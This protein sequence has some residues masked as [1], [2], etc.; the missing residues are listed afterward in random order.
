[1]PVF[2]RRKETVMTKEQFEHYNFRKSTLA[3]IERANEIIRDY[4]S[5][6]YS[7]TLRQLYYQFVARGLIENDQKEYKALGSTLSK[8]RLAGLVSWSSIEDRTRNLKGWQGGY[9]DVPDF[10]SGVA[11][12]Y[13]VDIWKGQPTYLE[14][15]VEKDALV[16]VVEKACFE[17]RI[18]HF[19]CRGYS[20]QSEQYSAGKRFHDKHRR[21]AKECHIFHLGDHDPSGIDMT[22]DNQDRLAMFSGDNVTV[23]RIALNMSQIE[24]L[25]PPPNPAKETDSRSDDYIRNYGPNSWELDALDPAYIDRLIREAVTPYIDADA[26]DARRRYEQEGADYLT[27]LS[28]NF[29]AIKAM[30]DDFE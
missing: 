13:F 22:R 4:Q 20:S 15:W 2:F 14:V 21:E 3:V 6:G 17:L 16:G 29:D 11:N 19:A 27:K 25:N 28:D 23:H 24:E 10:I 12:S 7:L 8:A 9:D 5:Q 30:L 26:M 1:M 18:P